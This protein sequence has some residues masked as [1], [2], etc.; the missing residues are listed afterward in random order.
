MKQ[1]LNVSGNG[2]PWLILDDVEGNGE[3]GKEGDKD[4]SGEEGG[5][6]DGGL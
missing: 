4:G 1:K 2:I 5:S 6:G 3:N